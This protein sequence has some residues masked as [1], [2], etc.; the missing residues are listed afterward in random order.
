MNMKPWCSLLIIFCFN[1][2]GIAQSGWNGKQLVLRNNQLS[3]IIVLENGK[4]ST[5]SFRLNDYPFNFVSIMHEEPALPD[6]QVGITDKKYDWYRGADPDEFSFLLNDKKVTGHTGWDFVSVDELTEKDQLKYVVTLAGTSDINDGLEI[7]VTYII[8]PGLPLIRKKLDFRNTGAVDFKIESLDVE[9]LTVPWGAV[10]NKVYHNYARN[11]HIGPYL[12]NWHDPLIISYDRENYHGIIIGNEAPGVMK[13]VSVCLD[14]RTIN[15]GLTHAGQDYAFRKWLKPG[16]GWES[17]W[18]FAGL[19]AG[20]A[21]HEFI[22]GPVNDFVRKHMGIRLAKI[23][24]KPAF[25]Y[26]TWQPFRREVNESLVMELADAAAACGVEEFIIDDGWQ[27]GF[28]DWEIDYEKFPN[29]LKPVF[30]YIKSKGMKPGLWLSMGAASKDSK[31]FREHPEWFVRDREGDFVNLHSEWEKD[32][33]S[34][35]FT[36]GWKDYIRDIILNLV[37]EHG[38]E[39][40]KLDFAI[41]TSAYRFNP[42]ISG[43]FAPGHSH[44]D[45]EESYL[46]IYRSAWQMFDKLH[47]EAPNLFIDCTFE[48]MG[49]LQ[50]IDYDMCKHAEGNWLS[51]FEGVAPYGSERV[52]HMSWWRSPAIPATAMVIGNQSLDDEQALYSFK[53]L[54]GSLP[55]MLGDPRKMDPEK[56]QQFKQYSSWFR[57]MEEKHG[58]MLYRQDL[59]GF[60]E[61]AHGRWD[62]FQRINTDTQ[63]GGIIGVFNQFSPVREQW[64]VVN[65]LDPL[66]EYEV[67]IAPGGKAI[68]SATG[69]QLK[70]QGFKVV[71]NEDAGGELFE[72]TLKGS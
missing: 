37:K 41:A 53:S 72:I 19:Y 68:H 6:G 32:R 8:Y 71:L 36:T 48:T 18:T 59:K 47:E 63:S 20:H 33:V 3:R 38:L 39:Y 2:P 70:E 29:G 17:T 22:E 28:G 27:I 60:G 52:R 10:H 26:N 9:S 12:G 14:N 62:G 23:P 34:A 13:R 50:L 51:N 16:E 65:Y 21:P 66:K 30:D 46:E 31:V 45:R 4:F 55:I 61:P 43:C 1:I 40:V 5:L 11:T 56:Q 42:D 57:T 35:C 64:V 54:C 25:V 58:I 24:E 49:A 7:D 69:R 15:A 44:T 67:K